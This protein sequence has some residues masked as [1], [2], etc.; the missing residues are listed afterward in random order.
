MSE[1][2]MSKNLVR[3]GAF[4]N[5]ETHWN[6]TA[7]APGRVDFSDQHCVIS[8]PGSADQNVPLSGA[9][10]YTFSVFTLIT[11]NGSGSAR[12]VFQPS[13]TSESIALAGNHGWIRQSTTFSTLA[14]TTGAAIHLTGDAGDVWFDNVRLVEDGGT[15]IPIELIRNADFADN[16]DEWTAS[17]PVGSTVTFHTNQ[18][19]L[20]LGGSIEQE[21]PVV[22]GQTYNF[23]IDAMTPTGG[24]GF[25]IFHLAPDDA[26]QIELRGS[27]GWD[28]YPHQLVIP[29]GITEFTLQVV[30][31]TFLTVDNLSL[32][33]AP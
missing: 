6:A 15:I 25:A 33:T 11:Y 13:A 20:N 31:T 21:I 7:T 22:P 12:L 4:A 17:T 23:S 2:P 3:N 10:S 19:Q 16:G 1:Q 29:M 9:T 14:G 18:C 30:G 8:A 28:T 27:G 5:R 32:K 26:P 24:H